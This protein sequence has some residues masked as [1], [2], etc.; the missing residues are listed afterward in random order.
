MTVYMVTYS[1]V[2]YEE[3][4]CKCYGIYST[5]EKAQ[6]IADKLTLEYGN[7]GCVNVDTVKIDDET[8]VFFL[9]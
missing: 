4:E 9:I 8:N 7:F 3:V 2:C 1:D 5:L 6:Q